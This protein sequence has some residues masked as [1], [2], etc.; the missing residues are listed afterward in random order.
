[1]PPQITNYSLNSHTGTLTNAEL[2]HLLRR[3]LVGVNNQDV[4]A[5]NGKTV[6]QC[7]SILLKQSPKP[8]PV[9]QDELP[10]VTD[11]YIKPGQTWVNTPFGNN[12]LDESRRT[13]LRMWWTGLIIKRDLS[14]TQKMCLFWHN[15]LAVEFDVVK[16]SR[17]SY[18]YAITL[19]QNALGNFKKIVRDITTNTAMLVYL[20]GNTNTISAPNENFARELM[21]LFTLGKGYGVQYTEDDV[22][23]V[24]KV[25][26][27]W[28]D[29]KDKITA[30]FI[31]ENHDS[32]DKKL[33][34]FFNNSIIKGKRGE[35]GKTETDELI[36]IIYN[37]KEAARFLCRNL[38]RWFV[39]PQV[40]DAIE[41]NIIEPLA[42]LCIDSHFEIAPV[43]EKLLG[44]QHFFD[45]I[46]RGGMVKNPIDFLIGTSLQINTKAEIQD[47]SYSIYQSTESWFCYHFFCEDLTMRIGDPP[48]VAGWP[49]Y[50]QMPKYYQWWVNSSLLSLR[51]RFL[52][53]MSSAEGLLKNGCHLKFD[54]PAFVKELPQAADSKKLTAICLQLLC[55]VN[56][57][58]TTI[59]QLVQILE[60][61][62]GTNYYWGK[63][64]NAYLQTP[65][66]AEARSV[67]EGRLRLFFQK[68]F[69]LP[70]YQTM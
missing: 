54:F 16:D 63:S 7:L 56:P 60:S 17:Y 53:Q 67:I 48:S 38:Y 36:D 9:L 42:D 59:E 24:A 23:A 68:I 65:D 26:T 43:L 69:S 31:P 25:L 52:E 21:E 11:P 8:A 18:Q 62:M 57:D 4:Q 15:H 45:P 50:Y 51:K 61:D 41:K 20:G 49:A 66:S 12:A 5:F 28:R 27:G 46:F 40:G 19:Q 30:V 34:A 32:S 3:C 6:Q 1:M 10:E 55:A 37:R 44:S 58:S 70:E 64:W 39:Y 29:D 13:M 35:D 22:K 2:L 14:L 33:S 47:K